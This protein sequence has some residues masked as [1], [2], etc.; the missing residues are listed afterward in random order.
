[1]DKKN[2]AA[3]IKKHP[4]A[5][6]T[7]EMRALAIISE[8]ERSFIASVSIEEVCR[9]TAEEIY[10][11]VGNC[12]IVTS[13]FTNDE[14]SLK[15]AGYAG[16]EDV[17][18]RVLE[19]IR[20]DPRNMLFPVAELSG[21]DIKLFSSK[22][23]EKY[24]GGIYELLLKKIPRPF[25]S[26][27]EKFLGVRDIY[28]M[29]FAYEGN[30]VGG[31]VL[32]AKT[33]IKD[34]AWAIEMIMNQAAIV[35]RE[36]KASWAI[37]KNENLY[38]SLFETMLNG[39]AYCRMIYENGIPQD[40]IYLDVNRS[41]ELQ[42]GIKNAVGKKIS[43]LI[44]G[45]RASDPS[46]FEIYSR[47]AMTGV[48]ETFEIYV[49]AL[50]MWFAVSVYSPE[51]EYFVAIFDVINKRKE[52]EQRIEHLNS[53]LRV[54]RDVNQLITREKNVERL[55]STACSLMVEAR[56]F[57]LAWILLLDENNN[58]DHAV[59]AGQLE[60]PD[61]FINDMRRGIFPVCVREILIHKDPL[62]VCEDIVHPGW[63]CLPAGLK[64]EG[65]GLV[66]RLE[67]QDKLY[68]VIAV[69]VPGEM[70]RDLE[71]QSL[72]RE[73]ADD[74]GFALYSIEAEERKRQIVEALR[75]SEE[76]YHST[77]DNMMEG[78]QLI[79]FRWHYAYINETAAKQGHRSRAEYLGN[80][81]M[82]MFPG[83]EATSMFNNLRECMYNRTPRSLINE[84]V[85]PD[86]STGVFE[87]RMQPV[88]EGVF[89][90]STDISDIVA[91]EKALKASEEDLRS[92][93]EKFQRISTITSD[94]A[95][96]CIVENDE[97]YHIDWIY[98]AADRIL[99]YS[100]DEI[101]AMGCWRNLV[102]EEDIPVFEQNVSGIPVDNQRVCEL[103]LRARN[104]NIVW[105]L[106]KAECKAD[107]DHPGQF[108]LFG[109]LVDISERKKLEEERQIYT[110]KLKSTV[111]DAI[112]SLAYIAETRD[113]YTAGHQQKVTSLACAI[114]EELGLSQEKIDTVRVA[115]MLHD[116]GKVQVP[117]E[118]L[119]KPT[120]LTEA[121]IQLIRCHPSVSYDI[122]KKIDM[123][124]P[125][126][127]II[128]QHH[129]RLD[130]SGYPKGIAAGD[131]I[132][133]ARILAVADVVEAM[134]S[135]RPY[136]PARGIDEALA[137]I[138]SNKGI[139]YDEKVVEACLRLFREK[140]FEIEG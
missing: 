138:S 25:C 6:L 71:E 73:L 22:K 83:I 125:V 126:A 113:P 12:Y 88:P 61:S 112:S 8:A 95:Y 19:I 104:G 46:I 45:I 31:M 10:K 53:V 9:I 120:R 36:K 55:L 76:R 14:Q 38:H 69:Y 132:F 48:P 60:I 4:Q 44:P 136:R 105:V 42:T 57:Q 62:A 67:Y 86:G 78:C 75:T 52:T 23:L 37:R 51:K 100:V 41:F 137:E 64:L 81:M 2:K 87:L 84:F 50:K 18:E 33:G 11:L 111:E 47:V 139:L 13:C 118:I 80:N 17:M 65:K 127:D 130:G 124:W 117:A 131:I 1:M 106:S 54:L 98:G 91:A 43:E 26:M 97:S 27:L 74:L 108:R 103:R 32:M 128:L 101:K 134:A 114:S 107:H 58:Y 133:E 49:Q 20:T 94:I 92:S 82:D 102:I 3:V 68:G 63:S 93:N 122:V 24:P 59:T 99:G 29:G 66:S 70:S 72:F 89:I 40:F 39:L 140:H 121:E 35:I 30:Y 28:M 115:S 129:E 79:D 77:L 21:I 110:R 119:S 123:P 90:L 135:H 96:S 56:G 5:A 15:I 85:Y 109:G 16:F 7:D 34:M 116:I